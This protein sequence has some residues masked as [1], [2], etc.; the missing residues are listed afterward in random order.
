MVINVVV[1][2]D[3]DDDGD[4]DLCFTSLSQVILLYNLN[5]LVWIQHGV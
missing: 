3:E 2:D 1:D 4:D 5:I